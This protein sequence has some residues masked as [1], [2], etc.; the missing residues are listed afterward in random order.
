MRIFK[1]GGAS[2]KDAEGIKNLVEVLNKVGYDDTLI[3]V[4]AMGK[5]TNALEKV[6]Y[7]YFKETMALKSSVQEVKTFHNNVL[8]DLFKND[9]HPIFKKIADLF[10][11][12]DEFL[13][14][15]KSP[16]YNYVYDQVVGYGELIST[17]IIS[18]YL[19]DIGL[20][21]TWIDV[22]DYIKTD[23][24]H[25]N[26]KVDWKRTQDQITKNIDRNKLNIT[27]GFLG[28]DINNFTTTLG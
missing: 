23:S 18:S 2:V 25:R 3:V 10:A 9:Q 7:N 26:A 24:Y 16:D 14:R 11:D 17:S 22:R 8:I 1:F 4:S 28:S 15:N 20:A 5:T 19:N 21:N 6:L 27:Q 12:L 13:S